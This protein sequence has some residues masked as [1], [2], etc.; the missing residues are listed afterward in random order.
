MK[1]E[2]HLEELTARYPALVPIMDKLTEA[3]KAM[4][5]CF[6]RGGKLLV[7][8]NGGSASDSQHIVAELMKG[9][10]KP[11]ALSIEQKQAF[12]KV[13]PVRGARLGGRLQCAL[14]AMALSAHTV[15]N[16]AFANDVDPVL[17][18]AQQVNGYGCKGDILLAIS[19][20]GN[21]ENIIYAAIAAQAAGMAVIG[22]TGE[23]GG[24]L[25]AFSDILVRMPEAKTSH[26]QE[27]QLPVYHCWCRML[28]EAF[29]GEDAY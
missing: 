25:A 17:C 11:R 3:Y 26:V 18:Y 19:T 14:R 6:R 16:T 2:Q 21:S 23:N 8:G 9:F 10:E 27:L 28:E 4:E 15:L 20:S 5:E 22:F 12:L 1:P 24:E 29:F 13:D 7:A